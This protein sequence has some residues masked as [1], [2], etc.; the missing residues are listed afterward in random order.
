M[1][2]LAELQKDMSLSQAI[3]FAITTEYEAV[4]MYEQI[5]KMTMNDKIARL[6]L[7]VAREEKVHIG[8]LESLLT[9]LDDGAEEAWEE[10]SNEKEEMIAEKIAKSIINRE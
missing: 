5:A 2:K 9:D 3:R 8:E 10:G 4:N 7:D 6:L 1:K